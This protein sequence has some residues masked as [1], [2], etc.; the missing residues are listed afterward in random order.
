MVSC[1]HEGKRANNS[2]EIRALQRNWLGTIS[3]LG[4]WHT[5]SKDCIDRI[6][7]SV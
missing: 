7:Q 2:M 6:G 4:I 5:A 1:I 3:W